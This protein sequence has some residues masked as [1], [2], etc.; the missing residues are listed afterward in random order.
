MLGFK[1]D[2]LKEINK[3]EPSAKVTVIAS[4]FPSPF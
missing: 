1:R 3:I 4:T 2:D